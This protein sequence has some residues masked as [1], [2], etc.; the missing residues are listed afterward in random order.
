MLSLSKDK[1]AGPLRTGAQD[2]GEIVAPALTRSLLFSSCADLF[3]AST[4]FLAGLKTW[5]PGVKPG[6]DKQ[7]RKKRGGPKPA[8]H[9]GVLVGSDQKK[10]AVPMV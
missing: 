2:E 3:R 9:T 7:L 8:S 5:M 6:H 4:S 1:G 10:I